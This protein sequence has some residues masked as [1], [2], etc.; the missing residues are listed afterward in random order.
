MCALHH[1]LGDEV[2]QANTE[3]PQGE[4]HHPP[5]SHPDPRPA[6]HVSGHLC[7]KGRVDLL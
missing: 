2:S 7:V 1:F 6:S 5:N 4:K 3:C